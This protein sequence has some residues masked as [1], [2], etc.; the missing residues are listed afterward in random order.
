[1]FCF[2]VLLLLGG[3]A[4]W[5]LDLVALFDESRHLSVC[6]IVGPYSWKP[7]KPRE[8]SPEPS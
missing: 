4:A 8:H 7:N 5:L 1:M 6:L 3:L 2:Y